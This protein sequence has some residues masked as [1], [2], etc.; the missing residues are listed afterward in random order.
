[1]APSPICHSTDS[2]NMDDALVLASTAV[3]NT[4]YVLV[5]ASPSSSAQALNDNDA[6]T[7][8]GAARA[9]AL[10][11]RPH[12]KSKSNNC[13]PMKQKKQLKRPPISDTDLEKQVNQVRDVGGGENII[14]SS[15]KLTQ[16]LDTDNER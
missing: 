8:A 6:E 7:V 13:K 16:L 2:G 14:D 15:F 1:M 10:E 3:G 4:E 9:V 12:K 5:V 11:G